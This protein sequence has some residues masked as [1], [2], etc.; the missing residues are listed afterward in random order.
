MEYTLNNFIGDKIYV[1]TQQLFSNLNFD[2]TVINSMSYE[3][4]YMF[5][6]VNGI[7]DVE[8][9]FDAYFQKVTPYIIHGINIEPFENYNKTLNSIDD[10]TIKVTYKCYPIDDIYLTKRLDVYS[11][12]ENHFFFFDKNK[13][14]EKA[15]NFNRKEPWLNSHA[16]ANERKRCI[17]TYNKICPY[18]DL[19]DVF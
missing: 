10:I 18:D 16:Y 15:R 2:K 6:K 17:E 7:E 9:N 14:L 4:A 3:E 19:K 5:R 12:G 13:A 8:G 1:L 11:F